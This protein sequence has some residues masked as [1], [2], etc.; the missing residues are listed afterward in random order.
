MSE[1]VIEKTL[2]EILKEIKKINKR[3]DEPFTTM[4]GQEIR[5]KC[6]E[7]GEVTTAHFVNNDGEYDFCYWFS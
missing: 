4:A 3:L 5:F 6:C 7:C 1:R 2:K